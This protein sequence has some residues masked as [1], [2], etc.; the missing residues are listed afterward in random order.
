ME[1]VVIVGVAVVV[2]CRLRHLYGCCP[3]YL[4]FSEGAEAVTKLHMNTVRGSGSDSTGLAAIF[5][6]GM[7]PAAQT[8]RALHALDDV[9]RHLSAFYCHS[10]SDS[11]VA[12]LGVYVGSVSAYTGGA[13]TVPAL[14][15]RP[16]EE[17]GVHRFSQLLR[18][19]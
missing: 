16:A 19:V 11:T 4:G 12:E 2:C 14:S 8:R 7:A 13:S 18:K 1:V 9:K 10:T 6:T 5:E 17:R 15:R 3:L